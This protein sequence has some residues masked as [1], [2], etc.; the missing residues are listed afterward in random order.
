MMKNVA[1]IIIV[2]AVAA[3]GVYLVTPFLKPNNSA[4]APEKPS[5]H[6][7]KRLKGIFKG[8][9]DGFPK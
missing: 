3:G 4:F 8:M 1:V 5:G 7:S 2:V 9:N 6:V